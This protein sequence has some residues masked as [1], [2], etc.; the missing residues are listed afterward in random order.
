MSFGEVISPML[1]R[2]ILACFFL[3]E[4]YVRAVDWDG[5]VTLLA[6]AGVPSPPLALFIAVSSMV[7]G[8]LSLLLG[9]RTR[10]GAL[11]LFAFTV[12]ASVLFYDYWNL[13]NPQARADAYAIFARNIA[14]AGGLLVLIGMGPGKFALDNMSG[15]GARR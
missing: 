12:A 13:A 5:T 3:S 15:K 9:F 7:L 10:L 2:A 11:A 14:I 6:L 1:G 4:A 8:G